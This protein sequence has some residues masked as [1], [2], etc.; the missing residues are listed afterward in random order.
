M[1]TIQAVKFRPRDFI[2]TKEN[3]VFAVVSY[4][5]ERDRILSFLRYIPKGC[6]YKKVNTKEAQ[7]ILKNKFPEYLFYSRKFDAS[8]HAVPP[9]DIEKIMHPRA[10]MHEILNS[11]KS[12]MDEIEGK[13]VK[14]AKIFNENG[15]PFDKMGVSGSILIKNQNKNSDIDLVVYGMENFEKARKIVKELTKKGEIAGL[16]DE[17]WKEDY[18]RRKPAVSFDEFL[19]HEKRKFN[20]SSID[21]TKFDVLLVKDFH[22]IESDEK[23]YKK[24]GKI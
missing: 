18:E 6:K 24:K 19:W 3:L 7:E 17:L 1:N 20:K 11:D 13:A 15:I 23:T 21:D 9:S 10:R 12:G 22:E 5:H 4:S 2:R 8:L 16:S 14:L